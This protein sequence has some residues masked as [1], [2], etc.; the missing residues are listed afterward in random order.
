MEAN[1]RDVWDAV[2]AYSEK[3]QRSELPKLMLYVTP[4]ALL[5]QEHVE[6]C[7]QNYQEPHIRSY[8]TGGS[9]LYK[10]AVHVGSVGKS[11]HGTGVFLDH[12][13]PK[14]ADTGCS[15]ANQHERPCG[16]KESLT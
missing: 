9:T 12:I 1:R 3:L 13:G 14:T 11:P 10:R 16:R 6:W 8:R 15:V 5:T 7:Q 4:G 2:T